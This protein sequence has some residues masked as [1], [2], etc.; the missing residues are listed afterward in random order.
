MCV[1]L[2]TNCVCFHCLTVWQKRWCCDWQI[3]SFP[4][5]VLFSLSLLFALSETV[6][7]CLYLLRDSWFLFSRFSFSLQYLLFSSGREEKYDCTIS[8][9]LLSASKILIRF[10]RF[11][12]K[13]LLGEPKAPKGASQLSQI[14]VQCSRW[15][16]WWWSVSSVHHRHRI[17]IASF[18]PLLAVTEKKVWVANYI[19]ESEWPQK[20][21]DFANSSR[22]N[23]A[24]IITQFVA[25]EIDL[26][27]IMMI[28]LIKNW[29]CEW[30]NESKLYW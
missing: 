9:C 17:P 26:L 28:D 19:G 21:G 8:S 6:T 11:V 5:R 20:L 15:W 4:V 23:V 24:T 12:G 29:E 22:F 18:S 3:F 30:M 7:I 1:Y 13:Y 10:D 14:S 27:F 16:L 25:F 2:L